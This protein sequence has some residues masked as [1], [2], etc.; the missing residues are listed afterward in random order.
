[1]LSLDKICLTLHANSPLECE[2]F[3][4]L[5]LNV[6]AGE[7]AVI[8]GGNG[9]GKSTLFN[10]ITGFQPLNSGTVC[11]DNED[12]MSL[13]VRER[14]QRIAYVMQDPSVGTMKDLTILENMNFAYLRGCRRSPLR[15]CQKKRMDQFK[16]AL[17]ILGLGLENRLHENV[18]SLSGGQRQCLSLIMSTLQP[19][20]VFLLDE[21][22][23]ALDP[24]MAEQVMK[25]AK[26]IVQKTQQATLMITHHLKHALKYGDKIYLLKKGQLICLK[27]QTIGKDLNVDSLIHIM[28]DE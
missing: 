20:K 19:S 9:A 16:D 22:T 28:F 21:I 26:E 2:L 4:N 12:L 8:L 11:V 14:S 23:A 6:Q 25:T 5:S 18:S 17:S 13:S 1:M 3:H 15:I 27:D 10:V 24:F 7:L